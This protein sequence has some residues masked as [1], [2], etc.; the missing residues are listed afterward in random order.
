MSALDTHTLEITSR[1]VSAAKRLVAGLVILTIPA[2]SP[3]IQRQ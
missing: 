3:A 1:E 2:E